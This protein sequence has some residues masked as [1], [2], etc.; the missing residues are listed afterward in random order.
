[1]GK[2]M[3]TTDLTRAKL[4]TRTEIDGE[5]DRV[6]RTSGSERFIVRGTMFI[7]SM[8]GATVLCGI[9]FNHF[10]DTRQAPGLFVCLGLGAVIAAALTFLTRDAR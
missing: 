7:S 9:V 3:T 8:S 1:M 2:T 10:M 5:L 6:L 4:M